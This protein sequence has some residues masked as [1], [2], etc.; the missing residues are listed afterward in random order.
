[1]KDRFK[2]NDYGLD[3]HEHFNMI[4]HKSSKSKILLI[5]RSFND[6]NKLDYFLNHS[7]KI[8]SCPCCMTG[9]LIKDDISI[10][11]TKKCILIDR[12]IKE[13]MEEV[14][15]LFKQKVLFHN[16]LCLYPIWSVLYQD[17]L[18]IICIKC[19]S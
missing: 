14:V 11:C 9:I 15:F 2:F 10:Y 5:D 18:D 17:I 1:M 16:K 7:S 3:K 13:T 8:L 6:E 12:Q 4:Q 19:L